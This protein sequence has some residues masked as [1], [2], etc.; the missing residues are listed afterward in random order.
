MLLEPADASVFFDELPIIPYITYE[1]H[2]ALFPHSP[3]QKVTERVMKI[4]SKHHY[5]PLMP[6]CYW[7]NTFRQLRR[8]V[9]EQHK[10]ADNFREAVYSDVP[11]DPANFVEHPISFCDYDCLGLFAATFEPQQYVFKRPEE[12]PPNPFKQFHSWS[13]WNEN[14]PKILDRLLEEV[15]A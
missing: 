10:E 4:H 15:P 6:I 7:S 8:Y 13:E 2:H 1:E 11:F 5:M 3:W 9:V 14:T 12:M